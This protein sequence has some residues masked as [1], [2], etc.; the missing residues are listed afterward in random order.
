MKGVIP[1]GRVVKTAVSLPADT[2]ALG[3]AIRKKNGKS[4]SGLYAEALRA[5]AR[6]L[7]VREAEARYVAGY[8]AMPEAPEETAF[9]EAAL[10]LWAKTQPKERW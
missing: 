5:Y 7:A 2:F 9:S 8:L 6:T 10:K 3:E 4:R 1:S